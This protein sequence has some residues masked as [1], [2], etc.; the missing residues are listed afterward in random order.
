MAKYEGGSWRVGTKDNAMVYVE[1]YT[2]PDGSGKLVT[3]IYMVPDEAREI[4]QKLIDNAN[5]IKAAPAT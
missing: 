5:Q 3:T 4:A 2:G 1:R